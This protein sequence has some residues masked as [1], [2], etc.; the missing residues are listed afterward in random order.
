MRYSSS[1]SLV[2]KRSLV[3]REGANRSGNEAMRHRSAISPTALFHGDGKTR[4]RGTTGRRKVG[5]EKE[6]KGTGWSTKFSTCDVHVDLIRDNK[7]S[8]ASRGNIPTSKF[9]YLGYEHSH[10]LIPVR[11]SDGY[12]GSVRFASFS[13]LLQ[14][15]VSSSDSRAYRYSALYK[16]SN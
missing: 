5:K 14:N 10:F 6:Q 3:V 8:I 13:F 9:I 16:G 11:N 7:G 4:I 2:R 1:D 15:T 12:V